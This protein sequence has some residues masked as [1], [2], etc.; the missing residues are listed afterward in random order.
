MRISLV[1]SLLLL[2]AT[3]PAA[4]QLSIGITIGAYPSFMAVPGYPVYYAPDVGANYFFFDGLYWVY[5][6]DNW[7][8]SSWYNGP[9][10]AIDPMYVP[11]YILQ[12]PVRYYRRPPQ[13][14]MGWQS[15]R[16]PRWNDHWGHD[17]AQRRQ[18]WDRPQD[19][20]HSTPA[21]LPD[22]QRRYSGKSYPRADQQQALQQ[23]NYRYHPQSTSVS[24]DSGKQ[25]DERRAAPVKPNVPVQ[26]AK[27]VQ[28]A[29]QQARPAPQQDRQ[30]QPRAPAVHPSGKASAEPKAAARKSPDS[31]QNAGQKP[32]DNQ[33]KDSGKGQDKDR[34]HD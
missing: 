1:A 4:A 30:E 21:P 3:V 19:S 10:D 34:K 24:R 8:S 25:S 13:Y 5:Q 17:W 27:P 11:I 16:P 23:Q 33:P 22:Y 14:F 2:T 9:W 20:A 32:H 29:P 18:D 12:I 28:P 26:Q 7:Y 15:D 31:G 6:D